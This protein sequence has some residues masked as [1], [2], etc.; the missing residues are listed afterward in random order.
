[1]TRA[2]AEARWGDMRTAME[3]VIEYDDAWRA[4]QID[5]DQNRIIKAV[6]DGLFGEANDPGRLVPHHGS[7]P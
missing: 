7:G 6:L 1:M 3:G 4:E 2:E 5:D